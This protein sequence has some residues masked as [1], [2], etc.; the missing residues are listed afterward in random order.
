MILKRDKRIKIDVEGYEYQVIRGLSQP[1][2]AV[3]FE[4]IPEYLAAAYQSVTHLQSLGNPVFNYA[5]GETMRL[6]L[7]DWVTAPEIFNHISKLENITNF[8]GDLYARFDEI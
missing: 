1:V 4:F 6:A 2:K 7:D 5:I 8:S 3:S